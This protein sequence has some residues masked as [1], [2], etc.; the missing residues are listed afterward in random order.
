MNFLIKIFN[1]ILISFVCLATS[2][3]QN[4]F[5]YKSIPTEFN[6]YSLSSRNQSVTLDKI[7]LNGLSVEETTKRLQEF[8]DNN[9]EIILPN[10]EIIVHK[11][12][13][14]VGD[15]KTVIF[16]RHTLLRIEPNDLEK[17]GVINI[18]NSKN[19]KIYNANIRG[20]RN[21]HKGIKGEW[22]QGIYIVGGH[23]ILIENF[24]IVDCW[25]DGI[26]VGRHANIVSKN[27]S[28]INGVVDN[29][30][31]NGIS[32]TSADGILMQNVTAANS[33]GVDPQQG[34]D[35]EANGSLDE[36]N[37]IEM[38]N[39]VTYN[40]NKVGLMISIHKMTSKK[41][42][43]NKAVN[44]KAKGFK[45]VGSKITGLL[46]AQIPSHFKSL[47]G[48]IQFENIEVEGNPRPI[49]IRQND[50]DDFIINLKGVNIVKPTNINFHNKELLRIHQKKKN[51]IISTKQ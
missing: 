5:K 16:Q 29:N 7:L 28:I 15:N 36:I 20:D 40:N 47:S 3:A 12:G 43:T 19:V 13:I 17:Y 14:T 46:I 24:R 31:R 33:N 37:N 1:F 38:N 27:V 51:I 35:F 39:I 44:I 45:D 42:N 41:N 30:R 49:I 2:F 11:S 4:S 23:N 8:I 48:K 22:G 25:G 50:Q 34:I 26:Y 6:F 21:T 10:R 32:V 18:V 9:S